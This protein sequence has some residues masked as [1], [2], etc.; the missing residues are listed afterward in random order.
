MDQCAHQ[1]SPYQHVDEVYASVGH[2][3]IDDIEHILYGA[4]SQS[5]QDTEK[6]QIAFVGLFACQEHIIPCGIF[7]I[8]LCICGYQ[9]I[10]Q[11]DVDAGKHP[12]VSERY[13]K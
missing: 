6:D 2:R 3:R 5:D 13:E 4:E 7:H 11:Q 12:S 9:I 8:L 1:S 10:E